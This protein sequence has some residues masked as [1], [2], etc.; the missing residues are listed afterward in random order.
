MD[1]LANAAR[2]EP[3][4]CRNTGRRSRGDKLPLRLPPS[5]RCRRARGP[6]SCPQSNRAA[7]PNERKCHK[8]VGAVQHRCRH[9]TGSE[10]ESVNRTARRRKRS[11][12]PHSLLRKALAGVQALLELREQRHSCPDLMEG[13]TRTRTPRRHGCAPNAELHVRARTRSNRHG[14]RGRKQMCT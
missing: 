10:R 4:L 14:R 11:L 3:S 8:C 6:K 7:S 13:D 5:Y 12:Q 9:V 1:V 2:A